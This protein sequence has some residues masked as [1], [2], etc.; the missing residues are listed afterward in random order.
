MRKNVADFSRGKKPKS[1]PGGVGK[2]VRQKFKSQVGSQRARGR[3]LTFE[4][5]YSRIFRFSREAEEAYRKT[6][7]LGDAA[8]RGEV[9]RAQSIRTK[10][11]EKTKDF[12][13]SRLL[14]G[15]TKSLMSKISKLDSVSLVRSYAGFDKRKARQ[16]LELFLS[17]VKKAEKDAERA[18]GA[19]EKLVKPYINNP[20]HRQKLLLI[21]DHFVNAF[22]GILSEMARA[23]RDI[24]TALK[25]V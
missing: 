8:P 13:F 15:N 24:S 7:Q 2:K 5:L 12:I 22:S 10:A 9:K 20:K 1:L 14:D 25:E 21:Q 17:E 6:K 3:K 19:Y 23:K 18:F 4:E 16:K 11:S